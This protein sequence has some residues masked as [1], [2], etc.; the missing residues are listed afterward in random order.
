[1]TPAELPRDEAQR[2][3]ALIECGVL[4]TE[5]EQDFDDLTSLAAELFGV[6]IALVSLIDTNR[7]WFKSKV[8]IDATESG[9][10]VAF[11]S[12]AILG[13]DVMVVSTRAGTTGSATTR[14]SPSRRTSVFT[15]VPRCGPARVTPSARCA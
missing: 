7:Q 11:C 1:M 4:D 3:A 10:D 8:G 2:I 13:D 6:P 5:A 15:R 14:S 12:H 9:R